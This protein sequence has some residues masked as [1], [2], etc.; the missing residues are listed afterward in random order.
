MHAMRPRA[1]LSRTESMEWSATATAY[2]RSEPNH[3]GR[4]STSACSSPFPALLALRNFEVPVV[5]VTRVLKF[6]PDP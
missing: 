3:E 1:M 4:D 6:D 2:E 5:R